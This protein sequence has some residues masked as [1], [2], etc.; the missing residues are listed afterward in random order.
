MKIVKYPHP[1][2][3]APA[4]PVTAIDKDVQLTAAG[5]IELMYKHEGLGLAA[6]LVAVDLQILVMNFAGDPEKKDQEFVAINPDR[7][8]QGD[9][10]RP[11]GLPEL[12][13]TLPERPPGED[14][15]GAGV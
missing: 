12:P 1:A 3:R 5:M 10:Q 2:L 7:R 6:P 11:R 9:R 4:R 13:G 15:E 8:E 14:G